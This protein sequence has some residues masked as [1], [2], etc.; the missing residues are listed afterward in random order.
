MDLVVLA[1]YPVLLVKLLA[2]L[3]QEVVAAV[4]VEVVLLFVLKERDNFQFQI[5]VVAEQVES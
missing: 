2:P 1:L 5:L 3:I 4:L